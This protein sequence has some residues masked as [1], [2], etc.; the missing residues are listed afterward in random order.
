MEDTKELIDTID[1]DNID[2]L[3]DGINDF[4]TDEC[5]EYD[6]NDDNRSIRMLSIHP[7]AFYKCPKLKKIVIERYKK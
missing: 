1:E 7:M 5:V 6:A 2:E 3:E 4:N